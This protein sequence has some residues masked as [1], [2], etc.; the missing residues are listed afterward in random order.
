MN[1]KDTSLHSRIAD[2]REQRDPETRLLMLQELNNSLP[3]GLRLDMPSLITNAYVRR[4]L[5]IIEE[6][7]ILAA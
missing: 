3:E 6:R 7:M 5:D 2:I 1:C 4:A